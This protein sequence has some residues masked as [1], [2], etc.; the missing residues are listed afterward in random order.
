MSCKRM[1]FSTGREVSTLRTVGEA[2]GRSG[3][4]AHLGLLSARMRYGKQLV[5]S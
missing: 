2:S 3:S 1:S 4:Q 5:L